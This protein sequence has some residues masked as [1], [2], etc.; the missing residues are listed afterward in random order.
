MGSGTSVFHSYPVSRPKCKQG[1]RNQNCGGRR[2]NGKEKKER[3]I[4]ERRNGVGKTK[5]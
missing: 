2:E 4:V 1:D 5:Q 3:I